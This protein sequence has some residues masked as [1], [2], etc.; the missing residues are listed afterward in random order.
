MWT[1]NFTD[2]WKL[3]MVC[4][5]VCVCVCTIVY[6]VSNI[7]TFSAEHT[8]YGVLFCPLHPEPP[9]WW[10][11]L[12]LFVWVIT[13]DLSAMGGP[14]RSYATAGIALRII[15]PPKPTATSKYWYIRKLRARGGRG[16]REG[17]ENVNLYKLENWK[18]LEC[19]Y[20]SWIECVCV[21]VCLC[22]GQFWIQKD[23]LHTAHCSTN[24]LS[25]NL[26]TG[27]LKSIY[28]ANLYTVCYFYRKMYRL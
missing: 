10:S 16:E 15:W 19:S 13:S 17:R 28:C 18:W 14:T 9:T 7:K 1:E 22:L 8:F 24:S 27:I 11:S 21:C 5:C 25:C 12:S 2:I 26:W 6:P 23:D 3:C 20:M 4:V